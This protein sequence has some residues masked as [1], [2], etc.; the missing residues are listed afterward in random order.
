MTVTRDQFDENKNVSQ[1]VFQ[2]GIFAV[3]ADLNESQAV[4]KYQDRRMLSAL[5][6]NED[7]R[8]G[9][10]F[11]VVGTGASLQVAIKAGF[12][13]VH[14]EDNLAAMLRLESDYTLT[15]FTAFSGGRT[16]YIYIDIEEKEITANDDPDIVNPT[17]G[18]TTCNDLRVVYSFNISEGSLPDSPPANHIYVILASVYKYSGSAIYTGDVTNLI[19]D[20]Y[21]ASQAEIS[22]FNMIYNSRFDLWSNGSSSAP[23]NWSPGAV[24]GIS[25]ESSIVL[26]GKHSARLQA[27]AGISGAHIT[28][29]LDHNKFKGK[30]LRAI[31]YA[32]LVS[33]NS[34][35]YA[36]LTIQDDYTNH[37]SKSI[38]LSNSDWAKLELDVYVDPAATGLE[39]S[40]DFEGYTTED[41][42][43]DGVAMYI[44]RNPRIYE[45]DIKSSL[46]EAQKSIMVWTDNGVLSGSGYLDF[47]ANSG[48]GIPMPFACRVTAM[49]GHVSKAPSGGPIYFNLYKNGVT[50]ALLFNI[51]DGAVD[52]HI[53]YYDTGISF[54]KGDLLAVYGT[55]SSYAAENAYVSL[56][57]EPLA[58]E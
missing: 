57:I 54:E 27:D 44:G 13:A 42:L 45:Q 10:G 46:K 4:L 26:F 56:C 33:A 55:Y 38:L 7:R 8:F 15:G 17:V 18:E 1:K 29:T 12:M 2:E 14:L 35:R 36:N 51:A 32:R 37:K 40:I 48:S 34:N 49:Y 31:A 41:L 43:V 58:G 25:R 52:G 28:Q 3:D 47:N 22:G 5:V 6:Q 50:S 23:D 20:H 30:Y 9:E 16:D 53:D 39:I 24:T 21:Q 11:E 19:P